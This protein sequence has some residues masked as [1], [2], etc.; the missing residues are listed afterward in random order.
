M[1]R[2]FMQ[3]KNY[4]LGVFLAV[5]ELQL[6]LPLLPYPAECFQR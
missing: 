4:F 2:D 3:G 5:I 1:N 6:R